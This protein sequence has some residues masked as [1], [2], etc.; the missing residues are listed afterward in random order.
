MFWIYY[1][2]KSELRKKVIIRSITEL[3]SPLSKICV[4]TKFKSAMLKTL[5]NNSSLSSVVHEKKIMICVFNL[6]ACT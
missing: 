5:S 3:S 6:S 2:E 1:K 4:L